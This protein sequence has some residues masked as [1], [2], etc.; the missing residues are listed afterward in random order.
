MA[1][2][3]QYI[4]ITPLR[5][6]TAQNLAGVVLS[7]LIS[8]FNDVICQTLL[9]TRMWSVVWTWRDWSSWFQLPHIHAGRRRLEKL[10]K[11]HFLSPWLYINRKSQQL[12]IILLIFLVT[13][14]SRKKWSG[15]PQASGFVP[16]AT[17]KALISSLRSGCFSL[18]LRFV[19][20]FQ[21]PISMPKIPSAFSQWLAS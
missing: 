14:H 18:S 4:Q 8:T 11:F 9:S 19:G 15:P 17:K 5:A 3:W 20:H 13:A 21:N 6:P 16:N 2:G 1:K 12:W 10:P 7:F